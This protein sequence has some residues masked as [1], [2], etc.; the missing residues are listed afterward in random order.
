M[1]RVKAAVSSHLL[2]PLILGTNWL[3]F[4]N[5]LGRYVGMWS[6]PLVACSVCV[7]LSNM[8]MPD[9]DSWEEEMTPPAPVIHS[10]EDLPLEQS[11]KK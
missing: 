7:A 5:L 1:Y 3:G 4:Y 9:A 2:H 11:G 6:W 8:G 10:M